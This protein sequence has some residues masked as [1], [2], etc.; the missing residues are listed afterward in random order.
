MQV[1]EN[2]F[3]SNHAKIHSDGTS[4]KKIVGHQIS[5]SL[6]DT[7]YL[8]YIPVATENASTLPEITSNIIQKLSET[9]SLM[10]NVDLKKSNF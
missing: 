4:L 1:V 2:V 8:G 5:T 7:F 6:G 9:Y 10:S 3:K